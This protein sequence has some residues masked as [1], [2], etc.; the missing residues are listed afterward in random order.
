MCNKD[1]LVAEA[2]RYDTIDTAQPK[3]E[4]ETAFMRAFKH[5]T[6]QFTRTP[7]GKLSWLS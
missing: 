6:H 3:R 7:A 4:V 2:K 1:T 5:G